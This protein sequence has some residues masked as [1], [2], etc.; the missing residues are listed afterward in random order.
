MLIALA[1]LLACLPAFQSQTA[2]AVDGDMVSIPDL[3]LGYCIYRDVNGSPQ[4]SVPTDFVPADGVYKFPQEELASL[5]ELR[6]QGKGLHVKDLSGLEHASSLRWLVLGGS[7]SESTSTTLDISILSRLKTLERLSIYSLKVESLEP[8]G[9]LENLKALTIMNS[10]ARNLTGLERLTSLERLD[11]TNNDIGDIA[12]LKDLKNLELLQLTNNK[13]KDLG[14][15]SNLSRLTDIYLEENNIED[16]RPLTNLTSL[17]AIHLDENRVTNISPF[18][19]L[20]DSGK[21]TFLDVDRQTAKLPST[22]VGSTIENPI[23]DSNGD[24]VKIAEFEAKDIPEVLIAKES[25]LGKL[26]LY[27]DVS[28]DDAT[29][30]ATKIYFSGKATVKILPA[31]PPPSGP[32]AL[33]WVA[34]SFALV[35][36]ILGIVWLRRRSAANKAPATA[37]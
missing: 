4:D 35:V 34:T 19:T 3:A 12:P 24:M 36:A 16:V 37:E 23:R 7:S 21:L 25:D 31:D 33:P 29:V 8:L 6:C 14:P 13:I 28:Q 5:E 2:Y 26:V 18:K 10:H 30:S 17:T 20:L 32:S 27:W 9:D 15:L 22:K 1:S 11:L